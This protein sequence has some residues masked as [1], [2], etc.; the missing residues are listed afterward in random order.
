MHC[1]YCQRL[2]EELVPVLPKSMVLMLLC[3]YTEKC[4]I[5]DLQPASLQ[6]MQQVLPCPSLSHYVTLAVPM[7]IP[8]VCHASESQ[9]H[10]CCGVLY[11][12]SMVLLERGLCMNLLARSSHM[13][14]LGLNS[15]L[16]ALRSQLLLLSM[17]PGRSS[18]SHCAT[19]NEPVTGHHPRGHQEQ[20][21]EGCKHCS[22]G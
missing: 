21:S 19:L 5:E 3:A 8:H 1:S 2:G 9:Q 4:P 18:H 22:S 17:G 11:C 14:R 16:V 15:I 7:L 6:Q 10:T 12:P 20:G 13:H